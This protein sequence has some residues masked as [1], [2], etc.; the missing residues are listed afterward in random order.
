MLKPPLIFFTLKEVHIIQ[1]ISTIMPSTPEY[2]LNV[3]RG[4]NK[5]EQGEIN[6]HN[7]HYVLYQLRKS[8]GVFARDGI[9][10]VFMDQAMQVLDHPECDKSKIPLHFVERTEHLSDEELSTVSREYNE[11]LNAW[12]TL[13]AVFGDL[14]DNRLHPAFWDNLRFLFSGKATESDS[15]EEHGVV[16]EDW[17]NNN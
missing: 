12:S 13:E 5:G 4:Y 2:E 9:M 14:E 15:D 11:F 8:I 7:N 3:P 6:K 16:G 10:R 1:L 17:G